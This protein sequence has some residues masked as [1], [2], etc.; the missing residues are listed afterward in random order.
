[1]DCRQGCCTF[2]P[3]EAGRVLDRLAGLEKSYPK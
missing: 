1:M 3:E 2:E